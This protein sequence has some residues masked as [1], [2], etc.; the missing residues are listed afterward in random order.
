M[1]IGCDSWRKTSSS[2]EQRRSP[3]KTKDINKD[4]KD[5]VSKGLRRNTK[6]CPEHSDSPEL[7]DFYKGKDI[8]HF[9]KHFNDLS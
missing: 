5:K 4:D 7:S 2:Q 1:G 6:A 8:K 9:L 3:T